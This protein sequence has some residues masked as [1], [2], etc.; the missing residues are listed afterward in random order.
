MILPLILGAVADTAGMALVIVGLATDRMELLGPGIPLLATG[1]ILTLVGVKARGALGGQ[2]LRVLMRGAAA[3]E[4]GTPT[5]AVVRAIGETGVTINEA[6]VFSFDLELQPEAQA[7]YPATVKQMVPRMLVG[8]VLPGQEVTVRVDPAAPTRVA[9]DWSQLPRQAEAAAVSLPPAEVLAAIPPERRGSAAELLA[10]GRRGTA[11][12]VA[13]R[14]LGDAVGTGVMGADD[15]RAG[16]RVALLE[17]EV[18]L[19]GRDPYPASVI[20][21][22]PARLVGQV[23]PGRELAVAVDRD[24]PEHEVAVDWEATPQ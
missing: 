5:R 24:D 23:G 6:P 4:G 18:K 17:L 7:P 13:I 15:D 22:L 19:P 16:A 10:R 20:H 8:A 3:I 11:R 21:W 2:S 14:D 9:I 12:L 1:T